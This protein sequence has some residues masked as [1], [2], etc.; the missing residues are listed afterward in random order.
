MSACSTAKKTMCFLRV[1]NIFRKMVTRSCT[2]APTRLGSVATIPITKLLTPNATA[3]ALTKLLV[4]PTVTLLRLP[5]R[6]LR[7]LLLSR[8][9]DERGALSGV[10]S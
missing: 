3:N 6:M 1:A 10:A 7:F 8:L 5:S 9:L 2:I 4:R